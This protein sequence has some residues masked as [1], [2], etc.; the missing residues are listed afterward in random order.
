M[1]LA[2]GG[3]AEEDQQQLHQLL[4]VVTEIGRILQCQP[5]L[6]YHLVLYVGEERSNIWI[7]NSGVVLI[8]VDAVPLRLEPLEQWDF[9]D[10]MSVRG[11]L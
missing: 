8:L 11:P 6:G 4:V 5:G 1:H 10:P 3:A 9:W 7:R 2:G